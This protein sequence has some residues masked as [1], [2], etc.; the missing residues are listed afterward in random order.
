ML[1]KIDVIADADIMKVKMCMFIYINILTGV[2]LAHKRH[3]MLGL[4]YDLAAVDSI[5]C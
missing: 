2:Q 1:V 5:A 3:W 4:L